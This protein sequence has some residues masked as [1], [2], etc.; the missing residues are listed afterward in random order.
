LLICV[1]LVGATLI[2]Y[3]QTLRFDFVS[4]DDPEYVTNNARVRQ[5]L[6]QEGV[7]WAFSTGEFAN[8]HPL[9]TLSHM[10]DCE[11]YG[12]N[13]AGH[14]ATNVVLHLA[15]TLILFGLLESTT[16]AV[17]PSAW[18]A[19]LFALHPLQVEPVAWVSARKDVLSTLFG[20]LSLWAY[21]AYA[22]RRGAARYLLTALLLALG[23]MCKPTLVTFPIVFL[24]MDFWPLGAGAVSGTG[25]GRQPPLGRLVV[26]KL[27]LLALSAMSGM[28]TLAVQA[29]AG[30]EPSVELIP[31]G[32]RA[33]NAV[34]S[35]LRY[36]GKLLWPADLAVLYPHPNLPGGT[37]WTSWQVAG[38]AMV[39]IVVS[40]LVLCSGRRYAIVGWLWYLVT[41]VPVSG[42]VAGG[43]EAMADRWTYV[44]LIGLLI[45]IA[46]GTADLVTWW[47][48]RQVGARRLA[49][50]TAAGTVLVAIACSSA[51]VRY[52]R[53]SITLYTHSLAA[54]PDPPLLHYNLALL[55]S[56]RGET[57][58]AIRHNREAVRIDPTYAE[59]FNN[60][61]ANLAVLGRL[62][63]AIQ[64]YREAL[65]IEPDNARAHN[66]LGRALEDERHLDEAIQQ[67]REA[68]K[69]HPGYA[70]AHFNLAR[71]LHARGQ[72][73]EA[74]AHYREAVRLSPDFAPAQ[75]ALR[76]ALQAAAVLPRARGDRPA[77]SAA[78]AP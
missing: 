53:D 59:A 77:G 3:A 11:L 48:R 32:L 58:E 14:H 18:V 12:L 34:L 52:W 29:R 17:W 45:V 20:F 39:L 19:A 73:E 40:A 35:Y 50:I 64:N 72:L 71:T 8:W 74:I 33:A 7:V 60:L 75:R 78:V 68:L 69:I 26:E 62:D 15:N 10:L 66:N 24:L 76:S 44:P 70:L 28:M 57:A 13:P 42:L 6:T 9:V 43:F 49:G 27:P 1:V 23:L 67:Y 61:G 30:L 55:L 56:A 41:L 47:H 4:L 21:S 2:P 63:E 37:P 22:R 5:G 54:A 46:W 65:R 51:Q 36:I 31:L 38:A 16:S 25:A